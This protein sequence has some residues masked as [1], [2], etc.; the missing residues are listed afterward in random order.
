MS[1]A[2]KNLLVSILVALAYLPIF[3][4]I[5]FAAFKMEL[6]PTVGALIAVVIT[7]AFAKLSSK[8]IAAWAAKIN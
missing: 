4:G 7:V 3:I 6:H 2:K 8:Y 1:T 5:L